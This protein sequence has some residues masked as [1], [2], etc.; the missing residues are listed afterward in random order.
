MEQQPIRLLEVTD[1][2]SANHAIRVLK[3][4][5]ESPKLA[6]QLKGCVIFT[7]PV[8]E[9]QYEF[10]LSSKEVREIYF[11]LIEELPHIAY[12]LVPNTEAGQIQ[13]CIGSLINPEKIIV[14]NDR[15]RLDVNE[16]EVAEIFIKLLTPVIE[17]ADEILDD[18][19]MVCVEILRNYVGKDVGMKIIEKIKKNTLQNKG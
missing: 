15:F 4:I 1:K 12:F 7:F 8:I 9:K 16:N 5:S 19:E 6:R 10:L 13:F 3:E 2:E 18:S 11:K 17:F 14:A